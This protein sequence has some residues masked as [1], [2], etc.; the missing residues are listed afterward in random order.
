VKSD[1]AT[2]PFIEDTPSGFDSGPDSEDEIPWDCDRSLPF[3][4]PLDDTEDT[5]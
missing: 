4:N 1:M 2:L 3:D 5:P